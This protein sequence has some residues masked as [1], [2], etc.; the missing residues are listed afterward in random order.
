VRYPTIDDVVGA[1]YERLLHQTYRRIV[2][3]PKVEML[4][5]GDQFI[6]DNDT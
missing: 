4:I 6:T 2:E 3:Y 1:T 5:G